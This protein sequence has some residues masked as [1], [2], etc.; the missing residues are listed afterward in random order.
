MHIVPD[1]LL[2]QLGEAQAKIN[3]LTEELRAVKDTDA[4][5]IN[6]LSQEI[7]SLR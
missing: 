2:D 5:R 6:E 7:T 4:K 1:S 3:R